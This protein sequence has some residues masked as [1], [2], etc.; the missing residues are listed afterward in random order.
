VRLTS[1]PVD[2]Y[3]ARAAGIV[4]YVLLSVVVSFGLVLSGRHRLPR[5]PRFALEDVHRFAGLLTGAFLAIHVATIAIDSYTPFSVAA[6]I[7]PFVSSF[8]PLPVA[9]GIVSAELL[10]ALAVTNRLR[11]R[12]LSYRTWRRAHYLGFAVW[13][14]AALHG[15]TAGTDR[16]SAWLLVLYAVS[17]AAIGGLLVAR[18][19]HYGAWNPSNRSAASS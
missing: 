8:R 11:N 5:W 3:A 14:A 2:W 19:P 4:A 15:I 10:V 16:G 12:V 9:L 17:I 7:V 18:A 6:L 1:S 13:A